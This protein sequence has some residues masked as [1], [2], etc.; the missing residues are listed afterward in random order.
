MRPSST[1]DAIALLTVGAQ[2][3]EILNRA[4]AHL[5]EELDRVIGI[6]LTA[7]ALL[8]QKGYDETASMIR[9]QLGRHPYGR[10][11]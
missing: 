3:D 2:G 11:Q 9:A 7:V 6:A 1:A 10:T 4:V 8:E 5:A